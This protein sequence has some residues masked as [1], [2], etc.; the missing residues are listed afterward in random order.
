MVPLAEQQIPI[1]V[2]AVDRRAISEVPVGR[3]E[4]VFKDFSM[5]ALVEAVAVEALPLRVVSEAMAGQVL[6]VVVVAL[7]QAQRLLLLEQLVAMV[8]MDF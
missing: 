3:E 2:A 6:A 8:E 7:H 1:R 5:L 4:M